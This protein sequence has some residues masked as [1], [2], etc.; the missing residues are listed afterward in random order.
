MIRDLGI[1]EKLII[2]IGILNNLNRMW[3][4][5]GNKFLIICIMK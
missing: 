2:L 1:D 4:W 5:I 3:E